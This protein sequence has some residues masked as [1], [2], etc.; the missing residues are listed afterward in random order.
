MGRGK[1]F[2]V[3]TLGADFSETNPT[4]ERWKEIRGPA[5][6]FRVSRVSPFVKERVFG[7][8]GPPC[9]QTADKRASSPGG[10]P[11][12]QVERSP[13]DV[14][15]TPSGTLKLGQ[16]EFYS[17]P[18]SQVG[19]RHGGRLSG[20]SAHVNRQ[21]GTGTSHATK[22]AVTELIAVNWMK[23]KNKMK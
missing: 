19:A 18:H 23:E 16:L 7:F 8:S 4:S 15:F 12:E 6:R 20:G 11:P 2:G 13:S 5:A 10:G 22:T 14:S 3:H 1:K 9:T 21:Q 17:F